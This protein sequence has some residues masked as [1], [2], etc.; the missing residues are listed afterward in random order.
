MLTVMAQATAQHKNVSLRKYKPEL[1][2]GW[3]SSELNQARTEPPNT[4]VV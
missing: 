4:S 3:A 1:L 2:F